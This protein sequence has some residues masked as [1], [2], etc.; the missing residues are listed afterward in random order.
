[1]FSQRTYKIAHIHT[2]ISIRLVNYLTCNIPRIFVRDIVCRI[3]DIIFPSGKVISFIR[4]VKHTKPI[5]SFEHNPL[6]ERRN[7]GAEVKD[8]I[9]KR[10]LC[11]SRPS[12]QTVGKVQSNGNFKSFSF[13]LGILFYFILLKV[14]GHYVWVKC[15]LQFQWSDYCYPLIFPTSLPQ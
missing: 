11:W 2:N 10:L 14:E 12:R 1:M 9:A 6:A 3:H 7:T 15:R 5:H 8:E 13:I 4:Q